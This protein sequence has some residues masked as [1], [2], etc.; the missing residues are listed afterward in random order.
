MSAR[1]ALLAAFGTAAVALAVGSACRTPTS[2][3]FAFST[4]VDCA[5]A[6]S[7]PLVAVVIAGDVNLEGTN[8]AP[9]STKTCEVAPSAGELAS[10]GQVV[11]VPSSEEASSVT[12]RVVMGLGRSSEGCGIEPGLDGD[13]WSGCLVARRR[14]AFLPN[15]SLTVE[16]PLH[17]DCVGVPCDAVSTCVPDRG[18]VSAEVDPE[19]CV[20]GGCD[21]Q[22]L[23]PSVASSAAATTGGGGASGS[24]DAASSGAGAGGEGGEGGAPSTVA[25]TAAT[26]S[27]TSS[28]GG[29]RCGDGTRDMDEACDDGNSDEGDH[30]NPD[31]TLNPLCPLEC[32][33]PEA[34]CLDATCADN[35][36]V[37]VVRETCSD[38]PD[39]ICDAC[40]RCCQPSGGCSTA[41]CPVGGACLGGQQC[42]STFCYQD[43]VE[44]TG[45]CC[46][47][48]CDVSSMSC[49]ARDTDQADGVCAP[50][51]QR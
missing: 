35:T 38:Y 15:E 5:S 18:C 27:S 50:I 3:T 26:T 7:P 17:A 42:A 43:P 13:P 33:A 11:A 46:E 32:P 48:A 31:C 47:S 23:Q 16:V 39:G 21:E 40:G 51:V 1:A 2:I 6:A 34:E 20:G 4:D 37:T 29:G 14:L 45:V 9:S 8:D 19:T 30:C 44:E 25:S 36:C 49:L 41:R 28:T 12:M 10:I 22:Q 24:T